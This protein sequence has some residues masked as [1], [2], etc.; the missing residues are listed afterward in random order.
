MRPRE[1]S[2]ITRYRRAMP[3]DV[4]TPLS[5]IVVPSPP[6]SSPPLSYARLSSDL[7]SY[8]LPS[9]SVSMPRPSSRSLVY[10]TREGAP[11]PL[12]PRRCPARSL[13]RGPG[14]FVPSVPGAQCD[15]YG[16]LLG[17][18]VEAAIIPEREKSSPR[19]RRPSSSVP[20]YGYRP[21][22]FTGTSDCNRR[23]RR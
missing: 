20:K 11:K 6:P 16:F 12:H 10:E 22:V 15:I 4:K 17:P 2:R 1:F 23:R 18:C 19:C 3:R 14:C 7:S 13:S 5:T 21:E 9:I 8:S